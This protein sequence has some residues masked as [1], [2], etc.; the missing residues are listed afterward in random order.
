MD[1]KKL[2]LI[3][4]LQQLDDELDLILSEQKGLPEE[5]R[6]LEDDVASINRQLDQRKKLSDENDIRKK[7]L[8]AEVLSAMEKISKY[9]DSQSSARNNKEYDALSKQIEYEEQ[10]IKKSEAQIRN[11]EEAAERKAALEERG[12]QMMEENRFDEISE[13]MMPMDIL[14]TQL[15]DVTEELA[16]KKAELDSIIQETEDEVQEI[17]AKIE[18]QR[19]IVEAEAKQILGKYDHLRNGGVHNAVVKLHR[20]ACSG[21]NT[22]VPTNRHAFILQ[23]GFYSCETCG[24]IVVHE[25]LFEE[26]LSMEA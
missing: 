14:Q 5:I 11:I 3:V 4:R 10:E 15:K 18:R 7:Q 24:R 13:D 25:R 19:V 20:H 9:K 21:C 1:H 17:E 26:A 6:D 2:K 22:R 16:H 12:R 8:K 23:G